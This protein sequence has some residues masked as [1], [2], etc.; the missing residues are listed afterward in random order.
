MKIINFIKKNSSAVVGITVF[1]LVIISM[2]LIKNL[3]MYDENQAIYG[4]RLDGADKFKVTSEQKD[5]VKKRVAEKTKSANVRVAGKIV[6]IELKVNDDISL[7]DAKNIG[8]DTLEE[9][10]KDQKQFFDFQIF[11]QNGKNKTQFPII[12]YKQRAKENISWTKDRA[13]S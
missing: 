12:G 6:N 2:L 11:I 9:F 13:E 8:K 10:T 7:E 1:I 4:T 3:F 5:K